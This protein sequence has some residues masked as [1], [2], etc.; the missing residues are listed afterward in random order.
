MDRPSFRVVGLMAGSSHDGLD[1][2]LV[3]FWSS[4]GYW[5][6]ALLS[7]ETVP[8]PPS[9][10]DALHQTLHLPGEALLKLSILYTDWTAHILRE[11]LQGQVFDLISWHGPTVFHQPEGGLTWSLGDSERLRALT[12]KPV[13]THFRARDIALGGQ[14]APLIPHADALLWP[15]YETL[16]NLGGIA[17]ITHCPT[18]T[19]FD[20]TPCNQLL[21]AL[22]Q[23]LRPPLPYDPHGTFAQQGQLIPALQETFAS[24]PVFQSPTP[25][26]ITNEIVHTQFI[27]PF[28]AY[29]APA[30]DKL[31]TAVHAIATRIS[32]TLRDLSCQ[33]VYLTGGGAWNTY[34]VETIQRLSPCACL[35]APKELVDFREAIGFAFLGLLRYLGQDNLLGLWTQARQNQSAGLLSL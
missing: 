29:P 4:Q 17:N 25:T 21:N 26:A 34:L 14:G 23:Q 32:Q 12:G 3:R 9:L 20:I 28:L 16:L 10:K 11:R 7:A 18:Y 35:L 1:I 6:Y 30:Q 31:H 19:A 15:E 13:V 27:A 8:Y 24:A 33:K 5:R 22:A 2:A